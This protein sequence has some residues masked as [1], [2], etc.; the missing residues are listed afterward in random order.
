MSPLQF[1]DTLERRIASP[2]SRRRRPRRN[3]APVLAIVLL[4]LAGSLFG[5]FAWRRARNADVADLAAAFFAAL[6]YGSPEEVLRFFPESEHGL[7]L[8]I[9]DQ[10][11]VKLTPP[12][13]PDA[14]VLAH[15][16][17]QRAAQ[18]QALR[19]EATE[20]GLDW[21]AAVPLAFVGVWAE[22]FDAD[23]MAQPVRS[24]T[25]YLCVQSGGEVFG[26][27]LT[28]RECGGG[29]VV[30]GLWGW[31]RIDAPPKALGAFS[32]ERFGVFQEEQR[33]RAEEMSVTNARRLYVTLD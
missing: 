25:G 21:D 6:Q 22:L 2:P 9:E 16:R 14:E 30:T 7:A 32:R 3:P 8:L 15:A 12:E 5:V 4:L 18:L 10:R 31:K 19:R 23:T 24:V 17:D 13:P 27:E 26:L 29:H 1:E 33:E 28:A 11:R 20:L